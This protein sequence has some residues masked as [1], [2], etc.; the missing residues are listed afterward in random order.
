[1]GTIARKNCCET[2]WQ[3]IYKQNYIAYLNKKCK[4]KLDREIEKGYNIEVSPY[5]IETYQKQKY[6]EVYTE[7]RVYEILTN[8]WGVMYEKITYRRRKKTSWYFQTVY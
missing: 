2:H 8:E 5:A 1:M 3:R 6:D 4:K 7:C